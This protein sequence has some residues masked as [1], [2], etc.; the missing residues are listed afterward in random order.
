MR[1]RFAP[2][3]F[4]NPYRVPGCWWK[5][6]LHLHTTNSDGHR[7]P[8]AAVETYR[9]LGYDAMAITDHDVL[10]RL[11]DHRGRP[12]LIPALE[13]TGPVA[14]HIVSLGSR[15]PAPGVR[16][17]AGKLQD[18]VRAIRRLGGL[19]VVAHPSWSGL[20]DADLLPLRGHLGIE[21][22]NHVCDDLNGRGASVELW[23]HLLER[24]R[25]VWGLAVDDAHFDRD[26][27]R[28]G[29]GHG[30]VM[31]KAPRLNVRAI[32]HALELG[33]FYA[34]R[35]PRILSVA[36]A[37]GR[38]TVETSPADRVHLIAAGCGSGGTRFARENGNRTRWTFEF[39]KAQWNVTGYARFEVVDGRGRKAWSNPL[40]VR[41][42]GGRF[43]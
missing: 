21:I 39:M 29:P 3:V 19:A 43:W 20:A 25:R 8:R 42:G 22:Y 16:L 24:G 30:W 26:G 7:S 32:L 18:A 14:P 13:A 41:S 37:P 17:G 33:S 10:T 5:V 34:T 1:R 36:S 15:E 4:D 11:P 35:G 28:G 2:P 9:R 12:L 40:F 23:D 6:A 27:L 38:L 31:V